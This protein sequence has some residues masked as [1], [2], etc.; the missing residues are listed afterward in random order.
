[1]IRSYEPLDLTRLNFLEKKQLLFVLVTPEFEAPTKKMRATLP[2][3]VRMP[4]HIWNCSQAGALVAAVLKGD[5]V[6]LGKALSSDKIVEPKRTP[7]IPGMEAVKKVAVEAGAYGCT[8]SG[9]GPRAVAVVDN[10]E[11][12]K[13]IG[14]KMVEALSVRVHQ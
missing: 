7:L 5:P 11:K 13:V 4:H 1:M 12:G 8:I 2:A 10:E 6:G 14:E 9:A 3:E